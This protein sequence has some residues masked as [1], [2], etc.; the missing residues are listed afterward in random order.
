MS[1]VLSLAQDKHGYIWIGTD[2]AGLQR[3]DGKTVKQIIGGNDSEHHV[4]SIDPKINAIYFSSKYYGFYKY[5]RKKI[6]QISNSLSKKENLA[7]KK[8]SKN[9]C[10]ISQDVIALT[11]NGKVIKK[12]ILSTENTNNHII[13]LL[14][15]KSGIIVIGDKSSYYINENSIIEINDWLKNKASKL[16]PNAARFFDNKLELID[17]KNNQ[18]TSVYLTESEIIFSVSTDKLSEDENKYGEILVKKVHAKKNKIVLINEK[19]DLFLYENKIKYIPK[20]YSKQNFNLEN[21]LIDVNNDLWAT[22]SNEGI[23]KI[24]SEPFTKI[25]LHPVYQNSLISFIFRTPKNEVIFSD[26]N[27]KT[28][29][30]SFNSPYF[31]TLDLRIYSTTTYNEEQL[32]ATNKG[33]YSFKNG[34]FSYEKK[35]KTKEK[36]IFLKAY[37]EQLFYSIENKGLLLFDATNN[38]TLQVVNTDKVTHV[39]TAQIN[40]FKTKL[41]FGT[42]NGLFE[43]NLIN[44]TLRDINHKFQLKGGYSGISTKDSYGNLWFS[45]EKQLI[46]ITKRGK[47]I[48]IKDKN[49]FISTLFYNLN[50]DNYGNLILGTN[51]GITKLSLDEEG[52]VKKSFHY[53]N[54]N[55]F[56]GY[57]THMRSNF[58]QG[59]IIYLGT[60]EGLFSINTKNL[61][62]LPNP[63]MPIIYQ[64]Q[65]NGSSKFNSDEELIKINYL[66]IN[67]K[68]KGIQYSY[69][70]KGKSIIWSDLTSKTEAYFSN[71]S[72][73]EYIFEVKSTYDGLNYS[74]IADY[75]IV[76]QTPIWKSKWFILFLILSI[77]LANIIVLD[78]SKNFEI[79]QLI[80]NQNIEINSK[81]RNLILLF[82]FLSMTTS[83]IVAA[84]L[85]K[86]L[87]NLSTLNFTVSI[88]LFLL[89]L[90]SISKNSFDKTK[91]YLLQI[92]LYVIVLHSYFGAYLTSIHPIYVVVIALS[93]ALTPFIINK[94]AEVIIFS[95][96]HLLA[97]ISIVF[98]ISEPIYNEILFIIAIIVS[99]S[100]SIFTTYIRNESLQKLIFVSSILNKGNIISISI[101][102]KNK[103]TYISE[104][105]FSALKI[106]TNEFLGE[107]LSSLNQFINYQKT[108]KNSSFDQLNIN[109]SKVILPMKSSDG[110]EIWMEWSCKILTKNSKVIFGQ[111]VSE[112]VNLE[113][114]YESLIE[115]AVDLIYTVDVNGNFLFINNKFQEVLGYKEIELIGKLSLMI[116]SE[117]F[118]Q[119]IGSFFQ[120]QFKEK[121]INTY[122]EFPI[123]K[124]DGTEIWVG[125]NTTMLFELGSTK[126]VKGFLALARDITEK[127]AQQQLIQN[128]HEDITS[129]I[130]YAKK[131]QE[132]L[133]PPVDKFNHLFQESALYYKPKDIVSGDFYWLEKINDTIIFVL[134][135]CTGHGV[136]G[137]FMTLLGINLLNQIISENK[138]VSPDQIVTLLDEKLITIL[139]REGNSSVRDGMEL[140]VLA[141]NNQKKKINYAC[142]GGKFITKSA[143]GY[144]TQRGESKHIGDSPESNFRKYN[145]YEIE[146]ENQLEFYFFSDG[147]QDQFG[148]LNNKKFTFKRLL[149]LLNKHDAETIHSKVKEIENKFEIWK[150]DNEQTDDVSFVAFKLK[151]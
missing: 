69:R 126:R 85:D 88:V 42:N 57:E 104:N 15:L 56:D 52:N 31:K 144:T 37:N 12:R 36:V 122:N 143:I 83:H 44:K 23:F 86:R 140:V 49:L 48:T 2:G 29:Y 116:I 125:Q 18:K 61:E 72:D 127:R 130:N 45:L 39:Y 119:N 96:M 94:I 110:K 138:I 80:E 41:Y 27:G 111:D 89:F 33:I 14:E 129:S 115:N 99:I 6:I 134:G 19:N 59:E 5:E 40:T 77:A 105:S 4:T 147:I 66:A 25:D 145:N 133:L 106:Y 117:K 112:R 135:D 109:E 62:Y 146:Y 87:E 148:S 132:N 151:V 100:L 114:N 102:T 93:T 124:K 68:L 47:F 79:S 95:I 76:K 32:F 150:K 35:Y 50:S 82:A 30:S 75:K 84:L 81:I 8:F 131:I 9:C 10:L 123:R 108:K 101:N 118:Q 98:L 46:G 43:Y 26:Y 74:P 136:P 71:L 78:R 11:K 63:P 53:T 55:G 64:L 20:N 28:Y 139:P 107:K 103:I 38:S 113:N 67:P 16:T 54:F 141:I 91:K 142:A 21:I 97:C 120:N 121:L 3:Y 58:Q 24:S 34:I 92:G 73:Q 137:S 149:E 128:Q 1:S 13:Q 70:L 65:E 7:I 90:L 51:N 60:I 17:F 22:T